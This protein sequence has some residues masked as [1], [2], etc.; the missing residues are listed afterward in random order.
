MANRAASAPPAMDQVSASPSPS[1]AD[2]V[3]T[4]VVSSSAEDA[5][6]D[7]MRGA[8]LPPSTVM[9]TKALEVRAPSV[10]T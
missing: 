5:A 2:R 8:M 3:A 10:M 4:A 9:V 1:S 7:R 6:S